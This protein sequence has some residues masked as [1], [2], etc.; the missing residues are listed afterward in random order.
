MACCSKLLILGDYAGFVW[1]GVSG[2]GGGVE[3]GFGGLGWMF[4]VR[5]YGCLGRDFGGFWGE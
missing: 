1:C 3:V 4:G 5:G 2:G